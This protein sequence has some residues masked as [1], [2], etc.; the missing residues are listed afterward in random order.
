MPT[1]SAMNSRP[2]KLRAR[3]RYIGLP[4]RRWPGVPLV[5]STC[6]ICVSGSAKYSGMRAAVEDDAVRAAAL[7]AERVPPV[8]E[9]RPL[10]ARGDEEHRRAAAGRERLAE[11]VRGVRGARAVAVGAGELE[12]AVAGGARLAD[13]G[14]HRGAQEV[15][16]GEELVLGALLEPRGDQQRVRRGQADLPRGRGAAAGEVG[17]DPDEGRHVELEAA[18]AARRRACDR[19]PRR[20]TARACRA[21]SRCAARSRPGGRP[22][23]ERWPPPGRSARRGVIADGGHRAV[24]PPSAM[25]TAPVMKLDCGEARKTM[26]RAIS[27]GRGHAAER[28]RG[29]DVARARPARRARRPGPR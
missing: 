2:K 14:G 22:A 23:W 3:P 6:S 21:R 7:E 19:S 11:V 16:V 9:H 27:R 26:M 24:N 20:G 25:T 5:L 15:G 17:D 4:C 13:R 29:A 18:V 1:A 28:M 8:V 12:E 10:A